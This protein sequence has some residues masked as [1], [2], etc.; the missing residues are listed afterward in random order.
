LDRSALSLREG[1]MGKA[2]PPWAFWVG[3]VKK[4]VGRGVLDDMT[5]VHEKDPVRNVPCE[6]H[7]VGGDDIGHDSGERFDDVEHVA[8]HFLIERGSGFVQTWL[9]NFAR[10]SAFFPNS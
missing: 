7:L 5:A 1:G 2:A 9:G 3:G 6:M 10:K 8:D 4:I